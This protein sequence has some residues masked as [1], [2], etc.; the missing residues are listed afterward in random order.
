MPFWA[1]PMMMPPT[2]LIARTS[3]PAIASPRTN[4]EAPSIAPWKSA[5][6]WIALAALARFLLVDEAGAEVGV[7]RHLLAGHRVEGEA[8]RDLGDALGALGDDDEVDDHEDQEHDRADDEVAADHELA[9][10]GDHRAGGV[11]VVAGE[12]QA[13]RRDVE[14]EPEQRDEQQQRRERAELG[15]L[16]DVERDQERQRREAQRDADQQ[17]EQHRRQRRHRDREDAEQRDR[18]HPLTARA[19][20]SVARAFTT[21][22]AARRERGRRRRAPR[23]RPV[24]VRRDRRGLP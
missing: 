16:L 18:H 22:T 10:R 20:L 1:T 17:V 12:D 11:R 2:T 7:D 8:R 6:R 9:E 14:R 13:R 5:S 23:R 19:R 15:R 21:L 24:Q 4:F 3:R